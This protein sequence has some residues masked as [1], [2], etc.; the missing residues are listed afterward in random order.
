[1]AKLEIKRHMMI[2]KTWHKLER[3]FVGQEQLQGARSAHYYSLFR[4]GGWLSHDIIMTD[5]LLVSDVL[6][7]SIVKPLEV[8]SHD[9]PSFFP[10]ESGQ[11]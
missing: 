5:P 7:H 3:Y 6:Y 10:G 8:F 2:S 11:W 4:K 9:I 1:M